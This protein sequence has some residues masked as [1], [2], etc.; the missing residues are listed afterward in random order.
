MTEKPRETRLVARSRKLAIQLV[1]HFLIAEE[2]F[3][4]L[5]GVLEI[6]AFPGG[7]LIPDPT[8]F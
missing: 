8:L 4:Q 3:R 7:H 2:P 5:A 6:A 1:L